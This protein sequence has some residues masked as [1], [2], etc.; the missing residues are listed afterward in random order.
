MRGKNVVFTVA[1]VG[2]TVKTGVY[3]ADD[4]DRDKD[5]DGEKG[6]GGD[7]GC[8]GYRSWGGFAGVLSAF[9]EGPH[10]GQPYYVVEFAVGFVLVVLLVQSQSVE[11]WLMN[12]VQG[13]KGSSACPNQ[14]RN[15]QS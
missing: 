13:C 11:V 14:F 5:E 7:D 10:G 2:G 8:H 3:V 6:E 12:V 4:E 1:G 15:R 9:G